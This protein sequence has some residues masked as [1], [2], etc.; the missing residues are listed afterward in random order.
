ME[1]KFSQR[2]KDVLTYSREEALR[3]GNEYI[4]VEHLILGVLRDG[5]GLAIQILNYLGV[6]LNQFKAAIEK[7]ISAP[8][9]SGIR[10]P[11]NLPLVRQAERALK[12]TYLE[13]RYLTAI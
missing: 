4:G 10:K 5:E 6:D 9:K 12:L 3:V 7:T 11:E 13:P 8:V 2:V 1:A